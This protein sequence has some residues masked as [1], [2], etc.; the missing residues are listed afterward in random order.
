M[1]LAHLGIE[2]VKAEYCHGPD[3]L[4]RAIGRYT[5]LGK[6]PLVQSYAPGSGLGHMIFMR[7]GKAL[8]K[9]QHR[10]IAEWPPEGGFSVI[11]ESLPL[12]HTPALMEKSVELLRRID[13]VGP[14]MVE[15]R[16][17]QQADRAVLMEVNGRFWGS[18]PL[19]YY[20]GAHFAWL[21]YSALGLG[22]VPDPRSARAGVRCRYVTPE[23]K[24][25]LR[26]VFTPGA[27]QNRAL[28]FSPIRETLAFLFR[29]ADLRF[30]Y[31]VFALRDPLPCV[32]DFWFSV[33]KLFRES[34]VPRSRGAAKV[35]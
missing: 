15:Y 24:R 10:R 17:D 1:E 20:S 13:W 5:A 28:R 27:I 34:F 22:E 25:L 26:I 29:F 16:Y 31:Y 35:L 12:E 11:C 3:A 6:L 23:L 18:L 8:L 4:R 2:L 7:D 9:F 21:T 14:A 30:R 32:V 19:A 33:V